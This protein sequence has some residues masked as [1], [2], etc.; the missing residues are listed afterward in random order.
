MNVFVLIPPV[1]EKPS[2][3]AA[4]FVSDL[5]PEKKPTAFPFS[6]SAP[7]PVDSLFCTPA[8]TDTQNQKANAGP[9]SD[10]LSERVLAVSNLTSRSSITYGTSNLGEQQSHPFVNSF[11]KSSESSSVVSDAYL[12]QAAK[13]VQYF[14]H[15]K[16]NSIPSST[17]PATANLGEIEQRNALPENVDASLPAKDAF[18]PLVPVAPPSTIKENKF[19]SSQAPHNHQPQHASTQSGRPHV[20]NLCNERGMKFTGV[21]L[22]RDGWK[23]AVMVEEKSNGTKEYFCYD[24][25]VHNYKYSLSSDELVMLFSSENKKSKNYQKMPVSCKQNHKEPCGNPQSS[26]SLPLWRT[27]EE[28]GNQKE[29][30]RT[31][32]KPVPKANWP[33]ESRSYI[34]SNQKKQKNDFKDDCSLNFNRKP[35]PFPVK[36]EPST[37]TKVPLKKNGNLASAELMNEIRKAMSNG[38]EEVTVDERFEKKE[39]QVFRK[40]MSSSGVDSFQKIEDRNR[41]DTPKKDNNF[42]RASPSNPAECV[43]SAASIAQLIKESDFEEPKKPGEKVSKGVFKYPFTK[44]EKNSLELAMRSLP[45]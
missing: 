18:L 30:N 5:L 10:L 22:P 24:S 16:N 23:L 17:V 41:Q 13:L 40:D 8:P 3:A 7:L 42:T 45:Q 14:E 20:E 32:Q 27:F 26:T 19:L 2:S 12:I 21:F 31:M 35:C 33:F 9:V 4:P 37:R 36:N 44:S 1:G 43:T 38:N 39:N 11:E 29:A 15:F 34:E 6:D 28:A 25:R